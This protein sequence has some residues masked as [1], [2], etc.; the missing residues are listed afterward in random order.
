MGLDAYIRCIK[1]EYVIDDFNYDHN[2]D[3]DEILY[4]RKNHKLHKW[5]E[6]LFLERLFTKNGKISPE[7]N[8]VPLFLSEL[9]ILKL[10]NDSADISNEFYGILDDKDSEKLDDCMYHL[11]HSDDVRYFYFAWY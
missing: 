8:C 9:D 10:L 2:C 6:R 11:K 5:M 4:W 7:F 1:K 3:R